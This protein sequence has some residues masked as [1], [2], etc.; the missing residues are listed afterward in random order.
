MGVCQK[1]GTPPFSLNTKLKT[2]NNSFTGHL[3][4]IYVTITDV[5]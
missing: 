3:R 4:V 1:Y 2:L 5:L